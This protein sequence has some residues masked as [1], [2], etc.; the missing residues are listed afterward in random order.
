MRD[1]QQM[2]IYKTCVGS[3]L[4]DKKNYFSQQEIFSVV[5]VYLLKFLFPQTRHVLIMLALAMLC[6]EPQKGPSGKK[7]WKPLETKL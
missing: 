6:E 5:V 3:I 2:H 1:L 4:S 7:S